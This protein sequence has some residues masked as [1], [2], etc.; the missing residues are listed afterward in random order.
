MASLKAAAWMHKRRGRSE[1][2]SRG[3]T[4][5]IGESGC[6]GHQGR[7]AVGIQFQTVSGPCGRGK[8][9]AAFGS[10]EL[11]RLDKSEEIG[12]TSAAI[13]GGIGTPHSGNRALFSRED[14][15]RGTVGGIHGTGK[16]VQQVFEESRIGKI[17]FGGK[18]P[19]TVG[20]LH[21]GT[22]GGDSGGD[23]GFKVLIHEG[24][25]GEVEPL[26]AATGGKQGFRFPGQLAIEGTDAKGT[27][28]KEY[29][30]HGGMMPPDGTGN[31]ARME[32]GVEG[33]VRS[34]GVHGE[35]V[36]SRREHEWGEKRGN[37][38]NIHIVSNLT[39]GQK[40]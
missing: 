7:M 37:R 5:E 1:A 11:V 23:G 6:L 28:H 17:V 14:G 40:R 4:N 29:R 25:G 24:N 22:G 34:G 18:E 15:R 30:L 9:E 31:K 2:V 16:P 38:G 12:E 32:F 19:E 35:G 3:G 13:G 20:G 10:A 39:Q 36:C 27:H 21:R 26:N 8:R 33:F